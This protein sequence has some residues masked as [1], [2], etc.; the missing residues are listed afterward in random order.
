MTKTTR[1]ALLVTLALCVG[2]AGAE[3]VSSNRPIAGALNDAG[4]GFD[5]I[6]FDT[7]SAVAND[8][9]LPPDS[10]I[11]VITTPTQGA[12]GGHADATPT[13]S[14]DSGSI[15]ATLPTADAISTQAGLTCGQL[16]GCI[17][18][19]LDDALCQKK[20]FTLASITAQELYSKLAQCMASA[21]TTS[22]Q[23]AC[24]TGTATDICTGCRYR[25]CADIL[26]QC[27]VTSVTALPTI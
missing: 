26:V 12:D 4:A 23:S 11:P 27:G 1:F 7:G 15:D 13:K 6:T 18:S 22:C 5:A 17:N 2:C 14:A 9:A 8:G 16:V 24:Q 25:V 19:C 21:A 10:Q 20:C 3:S